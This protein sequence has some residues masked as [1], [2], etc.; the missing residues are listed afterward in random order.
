VI[1]TFGTHP[2]TTGRVNPGLALLGP[3]PGT[4]R[5]QADE[6]APS[7]V[8]RSLRAGHPRLYVVETDF[9]SLQ[10]RVQTEPL[11]RCWFHKLEKDAARMLQEPP[12]QHRLIRNR[13]ED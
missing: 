6:P 8:L 3:R 12:V 10:R 7:D 2:T 1:R 9:Q 13:M 5:P 4:P 11:L